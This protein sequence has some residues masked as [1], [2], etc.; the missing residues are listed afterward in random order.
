MSPSS[1]E[2]HHCQKENAEGGRKSFVCEG[3]QVK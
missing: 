1:G 2:S 3:A